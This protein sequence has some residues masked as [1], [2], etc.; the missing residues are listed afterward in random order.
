[1]PRVVAYSVALLLLSLCADVGQ[2]VVVWQPVTPA[3]VKE[4]RSRFVVKAEKRD[5]GLI[6]FEITYSLPG[7]EYPA[8]H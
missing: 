2:V 4:S 3:S 8:A 7:P 6:H 1:M 5:D